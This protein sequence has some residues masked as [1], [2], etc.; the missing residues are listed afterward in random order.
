[1][2]HKY[3]LEMVHKCHLEMVYK[4]DLEV[5]HKYDLEMFYKY[6]LE[7]VHKYDLQMVHKYHLQMVHKYDLQMVHKY[8]LQMVHKYDFEANGYINA[9]SQVNVKVHNCSLKLKNYA[10]KR[11]HS[12]RTKCLEQIFLSSTRN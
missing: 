2:V 8:H 9:I 1:M 12:N 7:M 10:I 5:V 11:E 4:Y 3:D 6:H